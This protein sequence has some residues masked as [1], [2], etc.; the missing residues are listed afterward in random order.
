MSFDRVAG[1]YD[2]TRGLPPDASTQITDAVLAAVAATPA[3]RFL[4]VGI[5]TGRIG[6]PIAA[7]GVAYTGVD[8]SAAMLDVLRHKAEHAGI[9]DN[10][11]LLQGDITALPFADEQFDVVLGVHIF[12]LV[13]EWRRAIAEARRVLRP[14]GTLVV[15]AN[16][17]FSTEPG[18]VI[19]RQWLEFAHAM[20]APTRPEN[21]SWERL[22]ALLIESGGYPAL[23]RVAQWSEELRPIELME[24]QR[25]RTFSHSW[26]I[27]DEMLVPLH[28]QMLLW[29]QQKWHDLTLPVPT[30]QE[31]QLLTCCWPV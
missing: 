30:Q 2:A 27:P 9:G 23:F 3:T 14:G 22:E 21:G 1:I 16:H 13:S 24:S 31:F 19:R 17:A 15:G 29:G 25:N 5:G 26:D 11:Q 18:E 6:F 28:E 4:E 20:N 8:I 7:R 10:L 12:H